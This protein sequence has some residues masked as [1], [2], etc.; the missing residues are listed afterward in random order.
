MATAQSEASDKTNYSC[1]TLPT[2]RHLHRPSGSAAHSRSPSPIP[3]LPTDEDHPISSFEIVSTEEVQSSSAQPA[4]ST[5]AQP[6]EEAN[7]AEESD[8]APQ[9]PPRKLCVRHQR[10]A[11]EGTN[12]KIQQVSRPYSDYRLSFQ[13]CTAFR[14]NLD[15]VE[16]SMR[17]PHICD[18]AF[19]GT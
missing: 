15:M 4:D 17:E 7:G 2:P 5:S 13:Q 9:P 6:F 1:D 18:T 11:D 14:W 8:A 10:M 16:A 3:Q 19:R 12:L